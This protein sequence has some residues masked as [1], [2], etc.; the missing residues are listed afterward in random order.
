MYPEAEPLVY[1]KITKADQLFNHG[2]L[3][4]WKTGIPEG[5]IIPVCSTLEQSENFCLFPL[6]FDLIFSLCSSLTLTHIIWFDT[7]S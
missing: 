3:E 5:F 6:I 1:R 7:L 4:E 2:S